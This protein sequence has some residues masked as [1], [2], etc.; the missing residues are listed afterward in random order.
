MSDGIDRKRSYRLQQ[1]AQAQEQTRRRIAQAAMELHGSI[2]PAETTISAVAARAGVQRATVYRHYPDEV[3]LFNACSAHWAALHPA[4]DP[5]RWAAVADPDERLR[6]ALVDL[7]AWY[8]GGQDMLSNIVRDASRVA[9]LQPHVEGMR[10]FYAAIG[11]LLMQGRRL[12]GRR[13][14]RVAAAVGHAV[15]F[16]VW[17]ALARRGLDDGEISG[18]M[19]AFVTAASN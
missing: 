2:G 14:E 10:A 1:R 15:E 11:D 7:Y 9:A 19:V 4:P 3:A 6:A 5:G 16:E 13:R 17:R 18:L 8:R 12:R